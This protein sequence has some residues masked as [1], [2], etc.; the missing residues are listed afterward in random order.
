MPP[1]EK[2]AGSPE[3]WLRYAMSDL[4]LARVAP[5]GRILLESL[6]FHAQQA[7]E[8]AIKAVLVVHDIPAPR[9]HSLRALVDLLPGSLEK[10]AFLD[11]V[12][13]LTDYAVMSRYP[14]GAEPVEEEEYREALRLAE[15]VVAWA[16]ET[17][18][19]RRKARG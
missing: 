5:R 13:A 9:T 15:A 11:E 6:C 8:K 18:A 3:D 14:A 1:D 16:E 19:G 17:I 12:A 4:S 7:S 2:Q 10:P